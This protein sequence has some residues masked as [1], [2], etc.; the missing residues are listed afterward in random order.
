MKLK[1]VILT[2]MALGVSLMLAPLVAG[3]RAHANVD[4]LGWVNYLLLA[5][6]LGLGGIAVVYYFCSRDESE[7]AI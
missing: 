5:A 4:A 6:K 2:L 7:D 1:L 3:W